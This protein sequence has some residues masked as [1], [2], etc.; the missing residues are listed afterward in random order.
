MKRIL[1][2]FPAMFLLLACPALAQD[3]QPE[4]RK[5]V[6][7]LGDSR[8]HVRVNAHKQLELQGRSA[9]PLV[10]QATR[11]TDLEVSRRAQQILAKIRAAKPRPAGQQK[12]LLARPLVRRGGCGT[13]TNNPIKGGLTWLKS[14][15]RSQ[16]RA[17]GGGSN[18]YWQDSEDWAA[19]G[20]TGLVLLSY[21]GAGHSYRVGPY[22][23]VCKKALRWLCTQ[24][25]K[26]GRISGRGG[27]PM[28][29]HVL[30][31][32]A[33]TESYVHTRSP[34]LKGFTLRAQAYLLKA[35]DDKT[36]TWRHTQREGGNDI[37]ITV[38]GLLALKSAKESG[39]QIPGLDAARKRLARAIE[40]RAPPEKDPLALGTTILSRTMSGVDRSDVALR[41]LAD[42]LV[43][44]APKDASPQARLIAS[45]ALFKMGGDYWKRWSLSL[46]A[47]LVPK[48]Q[49]KKNDKLTG[50]WNPDGHS[51]HAAGRVYT[52]A[53]HTMSLQ[54]YYR[55]A[56]S[57]GR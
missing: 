29:N 51:G 39:L 22:R 32:L 18:G 14:Q 34:L 25:G 33:L 40:Q 13:K 16:P 8:Y 24:Q 50:S 5:W 9:I 30:A 48:Q 12:N 1:D 31:T 38:W 4:M 19:P 45:I 42:Q 2:L 44:C 53:L 6:Q 3:R 7:Q 43:K 54:V 20:T 26:D 17:K 36:G 15:Q 55:Y 56:K 41:R 35:Q 21:Q 28:Y 23:E 47:A 10:E 46:R 49:G 52:T 27:D 11:S 57:L 37:D